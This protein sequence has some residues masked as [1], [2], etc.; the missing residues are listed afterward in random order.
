MQ[1]AE[2]LRSDSSARRA[3]FGVPHGT[4]TAVKAHPAMSLILRDPF[5]APW[6]GTVLPTTRTVIAG[7]ATSHR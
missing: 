1:T 7:S 6:L 5:V 3:G 2:V 4:R